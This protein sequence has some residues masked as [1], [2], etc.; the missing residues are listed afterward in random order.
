MKLP[1]P[2]NLIRKRHKET[3]H[4]FGITPLPHLTL[5]LQELLST[6]YA[7]PSTFKVD[8]NC[9]QP[10]NIVEFKAWLVEV[11]DNTKAHCKRCRKTFELSNL[12]VGT[13]RS[14]AGGKEHKYYRQSWVFF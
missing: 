5:I 8:I 3:Q 13:L 9:E 12:G 4:E 11:E 14:H 10:L 1:L 7:T 6:C 2:K